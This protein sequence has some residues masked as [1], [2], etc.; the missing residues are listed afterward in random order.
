MLIGRAYW[1]YW[2]CMTLLPRPSLPPFYGSQKLHTLS[3]D[4]DPI[5]K[6]EGQVG[7]S[8]TSPLNLR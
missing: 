8:M 2:L 1:H 7:V 4:S 5:F 3:H 6:T